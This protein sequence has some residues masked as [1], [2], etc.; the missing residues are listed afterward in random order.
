MPFYFFQ[1]TDGHHATMDVDGVDRKDFESVR[2]E[3]I[4]MVA[5]LL[6]EAPITGRDWSSW[7]V[8][9]R[10]ADHRIVLTVPFPERSEGPPEPRGPH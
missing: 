9:V 7:G 6:R 1:A 8:E 3:A 2:S 5:D 4:E 10:D